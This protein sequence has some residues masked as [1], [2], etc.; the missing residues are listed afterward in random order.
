MLI[1]GG[2]S[3]LVETRTD[4]GLSSGNLLAIFNLVLQGKG[5]CLAT[6][7][8]LAA[9]HIARSELIPILPEWNISPERSLLN[10]PRVYS[11]RLRLNVQG[12]L[13]KS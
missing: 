13:P 1:R 11:R 5:I 7:G 10:H 3:F 12:K 4:S 8:W 2:K 9:G 6:P